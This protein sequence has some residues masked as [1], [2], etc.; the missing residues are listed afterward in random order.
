MAGNPRLDDIVR[1]M[2][3]IADKLAGL[4]V[5]TKARLDGIERE[6]RPAKPGPRLDRETIRRKRIALGYTQTGFAAA[7]G[8]SRQLIT[9]IERGRVQGSPQTHVRI[10]KA[11]GCDLEDLY[12]PEDRA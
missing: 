10:A 9:E 7:A 3:N 5:D 6:L 4:A 12:V 1:R 8:V 11:L 2:D